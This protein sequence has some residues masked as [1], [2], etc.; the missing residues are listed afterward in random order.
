V[1][2]DQVMAMDAAGNPKVL[3]ARHQGIGPGP[4]SDPAAPRQS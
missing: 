2:K 3:V 4:G 1:V